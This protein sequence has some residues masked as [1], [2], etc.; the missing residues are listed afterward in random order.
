[1]END[2]DKYGI[3]SRDILY[4]EHG[5]PLPMLLQPM[6]YMED[7]DTTLE[8]LNLKIEAI[9][10]ELASNGAKLESLA[11]LLEKNN[12]ILGM[13][14]G[15]VTAIGNHLSNNKQTVDPREC[16]FNHDGRPPD[17]M[18]PSDLGLE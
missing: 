14:L 10:M 9:K 18:T 6:L 13:V 8:N 11:K 5:E 4:D 7:S 16:M 17:I 15:K 1:M 12:R 2:V 3:R